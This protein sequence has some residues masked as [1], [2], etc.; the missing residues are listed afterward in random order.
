M[1]D[2][3]AETPTL[4]SDNDTVDFHNGKV[5]VKS[6][7][8]NPELYTETP[9]LKKVLPAKQDRRLPDDIMTA[10]QK[11]MGGGNRR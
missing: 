3:W 11:K 8:A 6:G 5:I 2:M 9:D 7:P 1:I 10:E 4:D